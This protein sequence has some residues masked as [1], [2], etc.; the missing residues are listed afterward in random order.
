M[1]Y[2]I[3]DCRLQVL[4]YKIATIYYFVS[5]VCEDHQHPYQRDSY[6]MGGLLSLAEDGEY[7]SDVYI[8]GYVCLQ[9]VYIDLAISSTRMIFCMHSEGY[10]TWFVCSVL[11]LS[12]AHF[13]RCGKLTC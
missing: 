8:E 1:R 2:H 11:C 13:L 5:R 10:G 9:N 6:R 4:S 12:N 3:I 7:R